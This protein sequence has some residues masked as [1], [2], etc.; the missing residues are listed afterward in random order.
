MVALEEK[1]EDDH[2]HEKS[3]SRE[4]ECLCNFSFTYVSL[5]K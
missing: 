5:E 4:Q 1:L 2:S 3:S